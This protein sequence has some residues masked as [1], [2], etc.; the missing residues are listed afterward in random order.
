[1]PAKDYERIKKLAHETHNTISGLLR[2]GTELVLKK[3]N[4]AG[5]RRDNINYGFPKE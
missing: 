2:E 1:M 3:Y 4:S 5:P